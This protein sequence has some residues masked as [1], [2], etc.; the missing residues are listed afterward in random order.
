MGLPSVCFIN[1][2]KRNQLKIE[3]GKT[4]KHYNQRYDTC[5]ES[6]FFPVLLGLAPLDQSKGILK[7]IKK[8]LGNRK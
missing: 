5:C 3:S 7:Q 1:S 2:C 6:F 8:A 4:M